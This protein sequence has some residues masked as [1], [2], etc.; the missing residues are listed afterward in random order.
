[1]NEDKQ[2]KMMAQYNKKD[3]DDQI[4]EDSKEIL[5]RLIAHYSEH[6]KKGLKKSAEMKEDCVHD[7]SA[8]AFAQVVQ[9]YVALTK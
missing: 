8:S 1:M 4:I 7:D 9:A 2:E 3:K 5:L 6:L